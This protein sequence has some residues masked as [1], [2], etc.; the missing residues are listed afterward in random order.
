MFEVFIGIIS[1]SLIIISGK[2][3]GFE[4]DKS[5]Y[6]LILIFISLLYVLFASIDQGISVIVVESLIAAVFISFAI[7]GFKGNTLWVP[8]GYAIHGF[9][10]ILHPHIV[11]NSGVPEWWPGFC[12]GIDEVIAL[13]LFWKIYSEKT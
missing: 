9:F 10:D 4:K 7:A 12:L 6:P 3:T 2:M 8:T 13:Y 1:G 5:F 11:N